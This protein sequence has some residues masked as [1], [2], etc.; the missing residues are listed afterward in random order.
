ML[1]NN[2]TNRFYV[3]NIVRNDVAK[4]CFSQW[5]E[6]TTLTTKYHKHEIQYWHNW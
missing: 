1:Q 4:V 6:S 3:F 5:I 2:W